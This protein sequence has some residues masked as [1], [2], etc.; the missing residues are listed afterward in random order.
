MILDLKTNFLLNLRPLLCPHFWG[1]EDSSLCNSGELFCILLLLV[2][3]A[4]KRSQVADVTDDGNSVG[5]AAP[6][7]APTWGGGRDSNGN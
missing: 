7:T 1:Q 3:T 6:L 2:F 4:N 5:A